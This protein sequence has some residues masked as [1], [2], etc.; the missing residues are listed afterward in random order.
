MK[1]VLRNFI[2][3]TL[4]ISA[5]SADAQ[6]SMR[7]LDDIFTNVTVTSDVEFAENIF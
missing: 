5:I 1:K 7:Y 3:L 2:A 4:I 6:N